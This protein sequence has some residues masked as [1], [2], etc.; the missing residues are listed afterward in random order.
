MSCTTQQVK[1]FFAYKGADPAPED[2]ERF[3]AAR[4][5]Q[6]DGIP[7]SYRLSSADVP[8]YDTC[9][10]RDLW[11]RGMDGA[12]LHAKALLPVT[13]V[14]FPVVLQFHGY[15]GASRSWL[16][17][18]SFV[19]MGCAVVALDCPGQGG[20]GSDSGGYR[21]T[22]AAGHITAGLDGAPEGMYYVRLYQNIRIL[23]RIVKH[24]PGADLSRVFVN[25]GSQGG[26]LGLGCCALNPDLIARAAI[27]Y[28][29]L[30]DFRTVWDLRADQTAYD[31]LRYYTKWFDP[32]WKH[33]DDVCRKLGYI[34]TKNFAPLVRCPVLFGTGLADEVCPPK[35]QFAVFNNL[36]CP[37]WHRLFEGQTHDEI[38]EFDDMILDFFLSE[39]LPK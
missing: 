23:C 16:E 17:Q 5:S 31:G 19:G 37:K 20:F 27:L 10:F 36:I 14:P 22:T 34:D 11:F 8:D 7:L 29:F 38:Q 32:E 6:A 9:M 26:A 30:S 1:A 3:W 12:E 2:F 4:M 25:G 33:L 35:T 21:G 18:A 13:S 39:E 28:P 15:P 24:L